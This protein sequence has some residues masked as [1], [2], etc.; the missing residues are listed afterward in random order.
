MYDAKASE[1]LF[2]R[3]AIRELIENWVLW[4]DSGDWERFTGLSR[5]YARMNT[6]WYSASASEF[7]ERSRQAFANGLKVLHTLGGSSIEVRGDRAIAET[8]MQIVQRAQVA[9]SP[10]DVICYGRFWD[11][12]ERDAAEG[13]GLVFR[14][15]IYELDHLIQLDPQK[16]PALDPQRLAAYPEG[17][18]HLAY[19]QTDLGFNVS[20][21][22]PGS[23][24][25]G[26][27]RLRAR[28]PDWLGGAEPQ[29][30]TDE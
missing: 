20:P 17:Y 26:V 6:S 29:C 14:Q 4:R 23:K 1:Q 16:P 21:Y 3:I 30:L 9:G 28:G 2:D 18:R 11:A 22:L 25:P 27:E 12:L 15:P 24:G 8:R 10:C 5:P 13:W 7:I 19:L